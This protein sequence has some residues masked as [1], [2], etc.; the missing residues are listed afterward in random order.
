MTQQ[1]SPFT[2]TGHRNKGNLGRSRGGVSTT[3]SSNIVLSTLGTIHHDHLDCDI[4]RDVVEMDDMHIPGI[5]LEHLSTAPGGEDGEPITEGESSRCGGSP[6]PAYNTLDI[7]SRHGR[8]TPSSGTEGH[9][10][11]HSV[12]QGIRVEVEHARSAI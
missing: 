2:P 1:G 4:E 7:A 6:A 11:A 10:S 5:D 12:A 3:Q 9:K 8:R